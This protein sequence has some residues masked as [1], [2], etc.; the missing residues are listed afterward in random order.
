[1]RSRVELRSSPD[2]PGLSPHYDAWISL[3]KLNAGSLEGALDKPQGICVRLMF[4]SLDVA[5]GAPVYS[6]PLSEISL[7]PT[8]QFT[9]RRYLHN[10]HLPCSGRPKSRNYFSA[11]SG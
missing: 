3:N 11:F 9:R 4:T 8:Q 5:Y 1:M 2:P 7:S 10:L 6:R